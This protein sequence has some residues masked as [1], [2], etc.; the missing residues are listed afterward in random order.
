LHAHAA[1]VR[2][3][4]VSS[5]QAFSPA[6]AGDSSGFRQLQVSVQAGQQIGFFEVLLLLFRILSPSIHA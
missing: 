4:P 2:L 5:R 3:L 6:P 1:C